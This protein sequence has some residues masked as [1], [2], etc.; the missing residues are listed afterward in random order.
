MS[1]YVDWF[2][3]REPAVVLATMGAL[4]LLLTGVLRALGDGRT[5]R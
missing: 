5:G 4:C 2:F 1:A 3:S